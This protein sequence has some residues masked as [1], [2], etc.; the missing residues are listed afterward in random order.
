V[1]FTDHKTHTRRRRNQC[2]PPRRRN[3]QAVAAAA[4]RP[5]FPGPPG[6]GP[7]WP[8]G[9]R[10]G[11][12]RQYRKRR[13]TAAASTHSCPADR[14]ERALICPG[15]D[16]LEPSF[17][18]P[19]LGGPRRAGRAAPGVSSSAP[20]AGRRAHRSGRGG[21][22]SAGRP[23]PAPGLATC[24][25][26]LAPHGVPLGPSPWL[27]GPGRGASRREYPPA[28]SRPGRL[29]VWGRAAGLQ[30]PSGLP[31]G[32]EQLQCRSL[33]VQLA[34]CDLNATRPFV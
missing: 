27:P 5:G 1:K 34:W 13:T 15:L 17:H 16:L 11:P 10:S 25:P 30:P 29:H 6:G 21:R 18:T 8:P 7:R 24:G 20:Q 23:V 4:A 3:A 32:G 28:A 14:A 12:A 19:R 2:P 33:C 31:S 22:A 9:P 26:R